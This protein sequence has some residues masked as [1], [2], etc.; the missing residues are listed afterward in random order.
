MAQNDGIYT[1]LCTFPAQT[2]Q[3]RRFWATY[4]SKWH[5]FRPPVFKSGGRE[6]KGLFLAFGDFNLARCRWWKVRII[7]DSLP[8]FV[9]P[10]FPAHSVL[11]P[12]PCMSTGNWGEGRKLDFLH[13]WETPCVR[14]AQVIFAKGRNSA[15]SKAQNKL[16]EPA[17]WASNSISSCYPCL[18]SCIALRD[19]PVCGQAWSHLQTKV[20]ESAQKL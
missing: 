10:Q 4:A 14:C 7:C 16:P 11:P 6:W 17:T 18:R 5:V 3:L 9:H 2:R 20:L 12:C 1:G 8:P 19:R 13:G 15:N